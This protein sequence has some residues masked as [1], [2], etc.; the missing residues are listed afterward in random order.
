MVETA[1]TKWSP[2]EEM[3]ITEEQITAFT[4]RAPAYFNP[5]DRKLSYAQARQRR[6]K[7]NEYK[8]NNEID[9]ADRALIREIYDTIAEAANV[10][11]REKF[12]GSEVRV[13]R[14]AISGDGQHFKNYLWARIYPRPPQTFGGEAKLAYILG[15]G[16][17]DESVT[18]D[19]TNL[20]FK[21]ICQLSFGLDTDGLDEKDERRKAF[22]E[23]R[24]N[25]RLS[26]S[27][28]ASEIIGMTGAEM[29][30]W[31]KDEFGK[32]ELSY[33]AVGAKIEDVPLSSQTKKMPSPVADEKRPEIDKTINVILYGPPGTGKTYATAKEAVR[34]CE[35]DTWMQERADEG[36]N[37]LRSVIM[38]KYAE[39][40][41][42]GRIGFVTFHQSM[43]YEEFVIGLR[44]VQSKG[45]AGFTLEPVDGIF[46]SISDRA[47]EDRNQAYVLIIDEINRA[48]ISKV[49]GELI[50]LLEPE[51]RRKSDVREGEM[52]S[53]ELP[54]GGGTFSVPSNLHIIGTMNTADRSIALLDT[55]LRR[56]FAFKELTPDHTQLGGN[57]DGIN[58]QRLL[59]SIND[60]IEYLFD[61]EHKIG[62]AYFINCK[63]RSDIADVMRYKV[64][65][66]LSEYF[67]ED[68]SKVATVLGDTEQSP[69]RF[70]KRTPM[71]RPNGIAED[72][73][74]IQR[75]RW[76]V[77]QES[78]RMTD[79]NRGFDFAEFEDR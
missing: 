51:K 8:S 20:D 71:A 3:P 78:E 79:P 16:F 11:A 33:E 24:R 39:L 45:A 42:E 13:I 19:A 34:I 72:D 67:Y 35:G 6:R 69:P 30:Q 58:L 36:S 75:F 40:R 57:V 73:S 37:E 12:P 74:A 59:Q 2:C 1:K 4:T 68:W 52:L 5:H 32:I 7:E 50:T 49:L 9:T 31:V 14:N 56:R 47:G 66:L 18:P 21:E 63:T 22:C 64:I 70:L 53:V 65:P 44:P 25:K 76:E 62:H 27:K 28:H 54:Y 23:L 29:A 61:R 77:L 60:R 46:K 10:I 17:N 41:G 48:N 55:A 38:D 26:F 15:F 43:S